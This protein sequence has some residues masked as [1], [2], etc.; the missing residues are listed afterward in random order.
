[1]Q[2]FSEQW[3]SLHDTAYRYTG[4]QTRYIRVQYSIFGKRGKGQLNLCL[5]LQ[6]NVHGE[7]AAE[8]VGT[9]KQ[10]CSKTAKM[11]DR[12]NYICICD[13]GNKEQ[14]KPN[15]YIVLAKKVDRANYICI[16]DN[17]K[18]GQGKLNLYL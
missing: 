14:G 15:L 5:V 1:M 18:G 2:D 12:A 8:K 17:G 13:N 10:I 9:A 16:C 7:N 3:S 6:K 11:V 4:L